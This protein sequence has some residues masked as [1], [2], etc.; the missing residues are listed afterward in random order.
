MLTYEV[1]LDDCTF[2]WQKYGIV[3]YHIFFCIFVFNQE[4]KV[5]NVMDYCEICLLYERP[6]C[7][8]ILDTHM[9]TMVHICVLLQRQATLL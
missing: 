8:V 1:Y 3:C 2:L 5:N 7:A 4:I 6:D 9:S